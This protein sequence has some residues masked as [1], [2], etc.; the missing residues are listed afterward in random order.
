[1]A[2]LYLEARSFL[3]SETKRMRE[4]EGHKIHNELPIQIPS[5]HHQAKPNFRKA[6]NFFPV[7]VHQ[8]VRER[9]QQLDN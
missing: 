3:D 8:G 7:S 9:E 4:S 1:V 5:P 6:A 2:A